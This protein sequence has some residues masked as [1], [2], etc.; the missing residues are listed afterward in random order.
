MSRVVKVLSN[1]V[2]CIDS[3]LVLCTVHTVQS[4][5]TEY[6]RY[7]TTCHVHY[8][9]KVLR[10][11]PVTVLHVLIVNSSKVSYVHT[12][13][14]I[15]V[16]YRCVHTYIHVCTH[17]ENINNLFFQNTWYPVHMYVIVI[18]KL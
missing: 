6:Y 2:D 4:T 15:H 9:L 3:R 7:S 11:S 1:P 12:Y 13:I 17:V 18:V 16:M 8:V 10:V 14:H 5:S